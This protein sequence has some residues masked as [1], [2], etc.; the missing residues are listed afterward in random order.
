MLPAIFVR[1]RSPL[2]P[3]CPPH[4][5]LFFFPP[6]FAGSTVLLQSKSFDPKIF[7]STV[8]PNATFKDLNLGR[9]RLKESLEQRSGAL[10]LLVEAEWDRFV[11]VKATT[12]SASLF[13]FHRADA[14]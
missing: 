1:P 4:S 9:E 10:K 6:S 7:L 14:D 3:S 13:V 2:H 8:H 11:G 12:E 5:P